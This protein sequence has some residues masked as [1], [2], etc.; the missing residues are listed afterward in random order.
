MEHDMGTAILWWC[1]EVGGAWGEG[2]G[3][4]MKRFFELSFFWDSCRSIRRM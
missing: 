2:G 1:M 3:R 4:F